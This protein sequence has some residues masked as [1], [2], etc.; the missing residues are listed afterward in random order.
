L[1]FAISK[2]FAENNGATVIVCSR[3]IQKSER[4]RAAGEINGKAFAPEIDI[5]S[6]SSVRSFFCSI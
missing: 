4:K 3:S 1:V 2:E 6:N 5:T